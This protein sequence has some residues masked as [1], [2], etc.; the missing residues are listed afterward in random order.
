MVKLTNDGFSWDPYDPTFTATEDEIERT[1]TR[2]V[3]AV[4]STLVNLD[5]SGPAYGDHIGRVMVAALERGV[6][7]SKLL[8]E[9][10]ISS[11]QVRKKASA[12]TAEEL[13]RKW[14]IGI[15]AAQ[16]TLAATTQKGI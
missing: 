7:R 4:E 16:A 13:A 14:N 8:E 11:V 2:T 6:T 12:I 3:A 1:H 15:Q 5:E 9:R 10:N